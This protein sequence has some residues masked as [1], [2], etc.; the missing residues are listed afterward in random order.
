MA[1]AV[2]PSY[3]YSKHNNFTGKPIRYNPNSRDYTTR[4]LLYCIQGNQAADG[5]TIKERLHKQ[6]TVIARHSGKSG[7]SRVTKALS[8]RS[9]AETLSSDQ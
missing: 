8:V 7:K 5:K 4:F 3:H 9:I 1:C 6:C 2:I